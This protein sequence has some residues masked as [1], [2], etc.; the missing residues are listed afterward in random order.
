MRTSP[1]RGR[2]SCANSRR[3]SR[4]VAGHRG[5]RR[6]CAAPTSSGSAITTSPPRDA[7]LRRC[8]GC[9]TRARTCSS[10]RA[11][12]AGCSI[13]LGPDGPTEIAP[14]PADLHRPGNRPDRRRRHVPGR[15]AGL[16]AATRG[17]RPAAEPRHRL[18]LRFAAAAGSLVVEGPGLDGV[19]GSRGRPRPSGAR[20][21]PSGGHPDA[22]SARWARSRHPDVAS[23]APS[24]QAPQ[25]RR[26]G[27]VEPRTSSRTGSITTGRSRRARQRRPR[28]AGAA[29]RP[30]EPPPSS[31]SRPCSG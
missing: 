2:A 3:G 6:S 16:D 22:R 20:A 29:A 1:S 31:P 14:L 21:D 28:P 9:F 25:S 10:P 13:H 26:G 23:G 4:S 5:R 30:G 17:R 27:P 12:R 8:T 7:A 19:P 24:A 11:P 18:D 15:A